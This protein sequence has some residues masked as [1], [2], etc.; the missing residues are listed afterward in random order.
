MPRDRLEDAYYTAWQNTLTLLDFP[1]TNAAISTSE[2]YDRYLT[3]LGQFTTSNS[4]DQAGFD[5]LLNIIKENLDFFPAQSLA[6]AAAENHFHTTGNSAWLATMLDILSTID[7]AHS[8]STSIAQTIKILVAINQTDKARQILS[9]TKKQI[10]LETSY[11]LQAKIAEKEGDMQAALA[12]YKSAAAIRSNARNHYDIAFIHYTLGNIDE[13]KTELR[14]TLDIEPYFTP[15][16]SFLA[17][18]SVQEGDFDRA[19]SLYE[20][21]LAYKATATDEYNLGNIY[22]I[23]KNIPDALKHANNAL[24]SA[25]GNPLHHLLVGE[26]HLYLDQQAE[27]EAALTQVLKLSKDSNEIFSL[28]AQATALVHLKDFQKAQSLL[29][30]TEKMFGDLAEI[31]Y[32]KALLFFQLEQYELA[33]EN[34]EAALKSYNLEW[35][36]FP[37]FTNSCF[38]VPGAETNADSRKICNNV[39]SPGKTV[40][41]SD[42]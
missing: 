25:P 21:I 8:S 37:W 13:A 27:A 15:A 12:A 14:T 20:G 30:H 5:E 11:E 31:S 1:S 18:L 3:L 32:I 7:D 23:R 2:S 10:N 24:A 41:I 17:N 22:F 36:D 40:L 39:I 29:N 38:K 35:F 33:T 19:I 26:I 9:E 16:L 28:L 34:M 4:L 42:E 6:T